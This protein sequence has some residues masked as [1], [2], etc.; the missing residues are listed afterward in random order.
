LRIVNLETAVTTCDGAG[1]RTAGAGA[2]AGAAWAAAPWYSGLALL[3]DLCE[4]MALDRRA[5]QRGRA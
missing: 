2:D 1:I 5:V 3:P 4:G